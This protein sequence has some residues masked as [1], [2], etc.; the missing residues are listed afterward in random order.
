[1]HESSTTQRLETR[2]KRED[3]KPNTLKAFSLIPI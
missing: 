2:M 3:V 1:M